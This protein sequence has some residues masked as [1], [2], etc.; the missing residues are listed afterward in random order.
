MLGCQ[1]AIHMGQAELEKYITKYMST[2]ESADKE[3]VKFIFDVITHPFVDR[4]SL[5]GIKPYE[6]FMVLSKD[7]QTRQFN[8]VEVICA[9]FTSTYGHVL[10]PPDHDH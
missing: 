7:E 6:Q 4:R 10:L 8:C 3:N 5:V 1:R 2:V 9:Q